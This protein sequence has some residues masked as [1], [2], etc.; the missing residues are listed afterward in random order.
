MLELVRFARYA[1]Y[2]ERAFRSDDWRAVRRCFH[3]DARYVMHGLPPF[4]GE[5][6]G[7]DNIVALFQRMLDDVDRRFDRRVPGIRGLPRVRDRTLTMQWRV[8]YVAGDRS[9]LLDGRT[10]CRFDRGRI[11]LLEDWMS[12]DQIAGVLALRDAISGAGRS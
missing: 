8:R 2:F 3:D 12:A 5:T 9:A 6:R 7:A 1:W 10:A 4:D 11:Q